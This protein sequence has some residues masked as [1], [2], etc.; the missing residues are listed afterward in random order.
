MVTF[1]NKTLKKMGFDGDKPDYFFGYVPLI[2]MV[3]DP[4]QENIFGPPLGFS[5]P[6]PFHQK[7]RAQLCAQTNFF[8]TF[9]A[10]IIS[11]YDG[12]FLTNSIDIN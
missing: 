8:Q 2:I 3:V 1:F 9:P 12:G 6:T 5:E 10:M 11:I 4:L 7:T